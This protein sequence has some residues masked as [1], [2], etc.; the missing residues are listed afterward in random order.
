[1]LKLRDEEGEKRMWEVIQGVWVEMLCF[2]AGRC[3]GYFHTKSLGKAAKVES[4]Y[5]TSGCYCPNMGMETLAERLQ[6]TGQ[7]VVGPRSRGGNGSWP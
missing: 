6:R 4:T 1:M 7:H 2:S 5:P 3:L